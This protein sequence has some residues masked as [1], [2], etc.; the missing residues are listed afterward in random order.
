MCGSQALRSASILSA[1][2]SRPT[3][4]QV[5]WR[6]TLESGGPQLGFQDQYR[7][8]VPWT[9]E[10]I[11]P[12]WSTRPSA[13]FPIISSRAGPTIAPPLYVCDRGCHV[14]FR[15]RSLAR[16][17]RRKLARVGFNNAGID[18]ARSSTVLWGH[19]V[20]DWRVAAPVEGSARLACAGWTA[21]YHAFDC[22][23]LYL[24]RL[25]VRWD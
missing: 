24:S 17:D 22:E 21:R 6:A 20:A 5:R 2:H 4:R 13:R 10:V 12:A 14:S 8:T 3:G 16:S 1:S 18:A 19:V 23:R 15:P 7:V 25:Q 9:D 11:A